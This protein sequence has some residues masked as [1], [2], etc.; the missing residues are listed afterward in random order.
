MNNQKCNHILL[1]GPRKGMK[2]LHNAWFPFFY[3][4]FCKKHAIINNIPITKGDVNELIL[5]LKTCNER[6]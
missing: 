6:K 5:N 2:C 3:P 4:C 1:K